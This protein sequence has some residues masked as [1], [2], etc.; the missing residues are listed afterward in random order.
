M[1]TAIIQRTKLIQT[2][3]PI[4]KKINSENWDQTHGFISEE[5]VTPEH[6]LKPGLKCCI[7]THIAI[8]LL[9]K[10]YTGLY[11]Y[12]DGEQFVFSLIDKI[13][14]EITYSMM[15]ALFHCAGTPQ[16]PFSAEPWKLKPSEV[17]ENMNYIETMPPDIE[18]C[19]YL[20][21]Y[22]NKNVIEWLALERNRIKI[23]K[24]QNSIN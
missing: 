6:T 17:L 2:L 20:M 23:G 9:H 21:Y 10:S 3:S 11:C 12:E 22:S 18:N 19:D 4:F 1:S 14:P 7:G 13:Y 8:A 5:K 15:Y 24:N 16:F